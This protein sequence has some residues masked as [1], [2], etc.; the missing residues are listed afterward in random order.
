M[1][2]TPRQWENVS[3]VN[4]AKAEQQKANSASLRALAESLLEQTC[5]DMQKQ[6]QATAASLQLSVRHIKSAKG[7]M[8][9]QLA[10]VENM[11][12]Q[13]AGESWSSRD[14]VWLRRT[15]NQIHQLANI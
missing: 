3:E 9:D 13:E 8:E 7:L 4:I 1:A 12:N 14:D 11:S 15:F 6:F 10:K 5:S 2:L